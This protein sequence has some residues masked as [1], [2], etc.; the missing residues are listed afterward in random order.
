MA[1]SPAPARSRKSSAPRPVAS[2]RALLPMQPSAP[3]SRDRITGLFFFQAEDGI[4]DVA[5][6]GVQTCALPIFAPDGNAKVTFVRVPTLDEVPY[7]VKME[8]NLVDRVPV[9]CV[10]GRGSPYLSREFKLLQIG[11]ASCRERV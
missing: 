4:R 6:T 3:T 9:G 1:P 7:P 5:V 2:R 11:R 10:H 8:P